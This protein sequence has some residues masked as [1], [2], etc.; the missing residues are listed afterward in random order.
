MPRRHRHEQ[1]PPLN[2]T[3]ADIP[4]PPPTFEER[5]QAR[6]VQADRD[7]QRRR[8][9]EKRRTTEAIDW[10]RCLVPTCKDR[11]FS[12]ATIARDPDLW[13]PL[14]THHEITVWRQV[15]QSNG[16][17]RIIAEAHAQEA[18]A[19]ARAAQLA[20]EEQRRF[21]ARQDG[22]IYFVRLNGLIK[23]GWSRI[24]SDRLKAYGPD[25]EV[26]CHYKGTRQ[27]ETNLH[28]NLTPYRAKGRE[29][30]HDCQLI[31]DMVAQA[32]AQHGPPHIEADWTVPTEKPIRARKGSRSKPTGLS[33]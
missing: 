18:I 23:V 27:D 9:A 21:L 15:Q 20:E 28:R 17:P 1:I 8:E 13:L 3:P 29:W 19:Q 25:V 4:K 32:V 31:A 24:L 22:D 7:W 16:E 12:P 30:Y 2:L 6:R 14:C 26:L 5:R 10:L 33:I 11:I